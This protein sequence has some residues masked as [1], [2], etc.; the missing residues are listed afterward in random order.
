MESA[1][2]APTDNEVGNAIG[3]DLE[4]E[5]DP[6]MALFADGLPLPMGAGAGER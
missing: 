2:I 1:Q 3:T 5:V 4:A 6:A